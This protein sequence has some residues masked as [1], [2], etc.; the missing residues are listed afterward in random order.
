MQY[1]EI[2]ADKLSAAGWSRA[3][4]VPLQKMAGAGSLMPIAKVA[5]TLCILMNC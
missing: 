5:T 1:W 4:A 3:I 2:V